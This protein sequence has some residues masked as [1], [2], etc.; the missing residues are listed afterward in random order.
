[1]LAVPVSSGNHT[2]KLRYIPQGT[3]IGAGATGLG[4]V[5][6]CAVLY[7][8]NFRKRKNIVRQK[9]EARHEEP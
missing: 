5:L 9:K 1:M 3:V 6:W 7:T 8:E 4:V 2:I